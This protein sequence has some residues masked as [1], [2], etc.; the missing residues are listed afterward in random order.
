MKIFLVLV[1]L[2]ILGS[3]VGAVSADP[4]PSL[5]GSQDSMIRQNLQADLEGLPRVENDKQLE[6][7]KRSGHF[8]PLPENSTIRIDP[9]LNE[10][11][12][13]V[14]PRA[15]DALLNWA[16]AFHAEFRS[17]FQINSAV[18]TVERQ[19][20]LDKKNANAAPPYGSTASSHLTGSTIDITKLKVPPPQV[21]WGRKFFL[22]M[23]KGGLVEATEEK[24]QA[25]FHIMVF[26][27]K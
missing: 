4:F 9:R 13:W 6:A 15:K 11:W 24:Y 2:S 5:K 18:R 1:V 3:S 8:V 14:H 26:R 21:R 17:F 25:V 19:E 12:R 27:P 7:F 20:Y 10:K 23:E 22:H 16:K